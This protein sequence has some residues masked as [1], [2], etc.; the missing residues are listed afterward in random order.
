MGHRLFLVALLCFCGS[1][2]AEN[3]LKN[4]SFEERDTTNRL[5]PRYWTETH[6]QSA[7][8]QF[9][10][11]HHDGATAGLIPGDGKSYLWRQDIMNPSA[12]AF[13][14]SAF[15]KADNVTLTDKDDHA[16]L[17]GHIIYKGQPYE[18]A[19]HFFCKI[20]PGTYDWQQI[21]V[22]GAAAGDGPIERVH[23]SVVG[24][25]SAGR[26]LVDQVEVSPNVELSPEGTLRSKVTDLQALLEKA[27]NLDGS[28]TEAQT[29]LKAATAAFA[30]E[31]PDLTTAH[32]HWVAACRAVSHEVWAKLFPECMSEKTTEAKMLYHGGQGS[33]PADTDSQLSLVRSMNC[34]GL[35]FSL[36]SWMSVN[37]PSALVPLEKGYDPNQDM[38]KYQ[39]DAAHKSGIKVFGY[40]AACYGTSSPQSGPDGLFEKHPEWFATSPDANMPKF[41]D[42]ANPEFQEYITKVY[43]ELATKYPIDGIGLDYIRYPTETALNY[44]ENNRKAILA[45]YGIDI[46]GG[47]DL[48]RDPAKWEKI[49]QYRG[50]VVGSL[51]KRV[52]D[53]VKQARPDCAIIAC[54]ISEPELCVEYGQNWPASSANLDY[55]SPMNYDDRSIN[56]KMLEAQKAIFAKNKVVYIPAVGGMPELHQQRTISEWAKHVAMQRKING[57]GIIIY[58]MGGLD[59]GVAAFFGN[60][61]FHNKAEFPKP[62][63]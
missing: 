14:L 32:N 36:G 50:E 2:L 61:P 34:N 22:V 63:K 43:V 20:K 19:T 48:S 51:V 47:I 55:A 60:G 8:L 16:M 9:T 57:D 17:Y 15:V 5:L 6:Y 18:S 54:L 27:G 39:I 59:Q 62:L 25:L 11:E 38:L 26:L 42:P 46:S 28:V 29:E 30:A 10:G 7:P 23:I 49:K 52:R 21:S 37:Y 44:D 4:S 56:V 3:L 33:T 13:T 58:R 41:P 40:L 12:R 31:K 53:A 35:L 1:A 45:K 24:K